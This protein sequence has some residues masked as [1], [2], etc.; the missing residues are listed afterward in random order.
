[1]KL[2]K[3]I[4]FLFLLLSLTTEESI[5]AF[6][7]NENDLVGTWLG[8]L[9]IQ[10]I[11]LRL[12]IRVEMKDGKLSALLDSPDQGTKDIPISEIKMVGDSVFVKSALIGGSYEGIFNKDSLIISGTWKQGG[13]ALPMELRKVDKVEGPKRPQEPKPP[14]PYNSED[15][16][17]ENTVDSVQLAGTLTFPKEGTNFPV[18]VLITGSGAQDRNEMAFNHKPFMV[19]ADYLAK[20]GIAALRF[21]DRGVGKSKGKFAGATSADFANDAAAAVEYLKTRK[22]IDKT[23]IGLAGHSEGGIIAPMIAANS[24][25]VAFIILLAGPGIPGDELL[26]QQSRLLMETEGKEPEA[27]EKAIKINKALYSIVKSEA[28]TSVIRKKAQ[29]YIHE[30]FVSLTEEEKKVFPPEEK[31]LQQ[32]IRILKSTW[33]K[34]FLGYNPQPALEK[35]KC[36]VLALNGEKDIQVPAKENLSAIEEALK[37]GGNK[38]YKI[39]ELPGLNHLFQPCKTCSIAEYAT[40]EETFTPKALEIITEWIKEITK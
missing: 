27:I 10:A 32:Q 4:I 34:Y 2:L 16:T 39:V 30:L 13:A 36:P 28:D 15:V 9:K 33:F 19:I 26:L 37:K 7:N 6:N 23:K 5:F 18:I 38:N 24:K 20:N 8:K 25:D 11:E 12:V 31:F 29:E 40:I 14:F 1:M 35:V 3:S 22:E 17:F 21:D